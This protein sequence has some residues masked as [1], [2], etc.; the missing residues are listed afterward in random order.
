MS[1][2]LR[3][4]DL[5]QTSANA[6]LLDAAI[7]AGLFLTIFAVYAQVGYFDFVN[8]DDPAVTYE[9]PDIQLGLTPAGI[10]WAF[11]TVMIGH[12]I[13]VTLLSHLLD[14]QLFGMRSGRHHLVNVLLHILNALLLFAILRRA[15]G[16]RW[17]SAFVALGFGVH[18]LHVESVAWISER[19]DVLSTFFWFLALYAYLRYCE[20]PNL[21]RYLM[22]VAPF[23]L[24][25]L[26]KPMLVTFPFTLLLL[27][28]W[29]LRRVQFPK[30]LW[31]KAPLLVLSAIFCAV[32]YATQT[33]SL[34]TVFVP[35]TTRIESA[36]ISYV[37]YIGKMFWPTHLTVFY[38]VQESVALWQP[39]CALAVLAGISALAIYTRR[40]RP[41]FITGWCWYLG[42][43]V[44]VIGVVQMGTP[45][46][47][48]YTYV[49][50]IGLLWILA[51]GAADVARKW[52]RSEYALVAIAALMSQTCMELSWKQTGY[53]Q[54]GV[55]LFQHEIAE[56]GKS[57]WALY[58]LSWAEYLMGIKWLNIGHSAEAIGAFEEALRTRPEFPEAHNSLGTVLTGM[59]G[60][61]AD[62][63]G[64]YETALRINP[65]MEAAHR[66]LGILL[67]SVQGRESEAMTHLEAAESIQPDP[68]TEDLIRRLQI[69]MNMK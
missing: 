63:L 17:S 46:A 15:T 19:K 12:W 48:R 25:L 57:V 16:A 41:Y 65:N 20:L 45:F 33:F 6:W 58:Y 60:R 40:T 13:P 43:L 66:N 30:T 56:T 9:N 22:V 14:V 59:P 28:V 61:W 54:N 52:P 21:R 26:S 23:C 8:I 53:W 31:E 37:T 18:P 32:T 62:A 69:R 35:L 1:T 11:T 4:N 5:Q 27:D 38:P 34:N 10:K 51:W 7:R 68:K 50:M 64:H 49:P 67:S 44:P 39:V 3:S 47:D 24:G 2:A 36:L 55:T 42:T 29:P